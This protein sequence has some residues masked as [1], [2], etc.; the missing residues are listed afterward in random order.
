MNV[1]F[2]FHA[3][4]VAYHLGLIETKVDEIAAREGVPEH[5]RLGLETTLAS[6]PWPKRRH[7]ALVLQGLSA[8]SDDPAVRTAVHV[9]LSA[10]ARVWDERVPGLDG[11]EADAC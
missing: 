7:L 4:E 6:L 9:V 5:K 8:H 3:R 2:Q 11:A 1:P 10:A